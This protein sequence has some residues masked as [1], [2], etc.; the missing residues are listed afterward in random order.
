FHRRGIGRTL[1]EAVE[2]HL[3]SSVVRSIRLEVAVDNLGAQN[4]YKRMGYG[5]A[6]RIPGYYAG[7]L[8]A[9]VMTKPISESQPLQP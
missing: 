5:V 6:G 8:D 9:F 3:C 7:F 4:F 1:L 2:E